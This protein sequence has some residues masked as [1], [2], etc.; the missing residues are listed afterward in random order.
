MSPDGDHRRPPLQTETEDVTGQRE[1]VSDDTQPISVLQDELPPASF[2]KTMLA[3]FKQMEE[4]QARNRQLVPLRTKSEPSTPVRRPIPTNDE[5]RRKVPPPT[6]PTPSSFSTVSST[7][8]QSSSGDGVTGDACVSPRDGAPLETVDEMPQRGFAKNLLA[9]WRMLEAQDICAKERSEQK[10]RPP[11]TTRS[12][13]LSRI[14]EN[15]RS[16]FERA[17]C[18]SKSYAVADSESVSET[19]SVTLGEEGGPGQHLS[20]T[21]TGQESSSCDEDYLPPPLM[22][23]YVLA[24]FRDLEQESQIIAGIQPKPRKV[25]FSREHVHVIYVNVW[26]VCIYIHWR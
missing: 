26:L 20:V 23:R 3:K 22:T 9:Q 2:T 18:M 12:Q 1:R 16:Y 25:Y 19:S 11:V 13:S 21:G 8:G 14:E 24:K 15:Q 5:G 17:A 10:K 6:R 4:E 7:E